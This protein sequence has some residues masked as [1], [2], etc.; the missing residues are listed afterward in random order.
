[1]RFET[2]R[3]RVYRSFG[4]WAVIPESAHHEYN[5]PATIPSPRKRPSDPQFPLLD[6]ADDLELPRTKRLPVGPRRQCSFFSRHSSEAS[7]ASRQGPS[8]S[9]AC[10][11]AL[12]AASER[13]P[14]SRNTFSPA[15]VWRLGA[16]SRPYASGDTSSLATLRNDP[17]IF[18]TSP[19]MSQRYRGRTL[20][21]NWLKLALR[22]AINPNRIQLVPQK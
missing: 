17:Q 10:R 16:P 13:L 2:S 20:V 4:A 14:V 12:P 8:P 21:E 5:P 11:P 3:G 19:S 7:R 15:V 9:P 6:Q 18:L 1:M 22:P